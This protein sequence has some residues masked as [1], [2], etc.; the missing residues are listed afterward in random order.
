[1]FYNR[2][3]LVAS[4]PFYAMDSAAWFFETNVRDTTG[5]FGS[6]T[7]AINGAIECSGGSSETARRRYDVFVAVA[8]AVGLT[9]YSERGCYN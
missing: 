5:Q 8:N 3:E 9:G 2:P 7:R 4:D 6:T 1:M